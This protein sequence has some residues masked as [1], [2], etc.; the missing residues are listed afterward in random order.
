MK[1]LTLELKRF[2]KNQLYFIYQRA[3]NKCIDAAKTKLAKVRLNNLLELV[4]EEIIQ[5]EYF[6]ERNDN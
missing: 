2:G 5:V 1:N 6:K 4:A 3:K